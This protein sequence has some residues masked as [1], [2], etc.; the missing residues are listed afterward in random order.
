MSQRPAVALRKLLEALPDESFQFSGNPDQLISSVTWDYQAVGPGALYFCLEQEEFQEEHIQD[1]S[2]YHWKDALDAGAVCLVVKQ[3]SLSQVP[4][5]ISLIEVQNVNRAL[6]EISRAF[7]ENPFEKMKVIGITGTNG[8][9]TTSQLI[10]SILLCNKKKTGIIGTIGVFYPSG[11]QKTSHL[12]NP[13]ATELFSIGDQMRKEQVDYL[14][15]EVTS[16]AMAFERNYGIDFDVGVFTN[17]SQDHLDYHKTFDDYKS[18][19]LMHFESLGRRGK[20][21]FAVVNL[22]DTCG[23]EFI[24]ATDRHLRSTGKVEVLTFG[25]TN[26]EAV[27][28]A[29]PKNMTGAMSEFDVFLKSNFLCKIQLPMP[30]IFN[31]YNAM[32]AF[33]AAFTLGVNI[34]TIVQGLENARSIEGRFERL[35]TP[36]NFQ[37]FVDYAHTP[38]S[39]TQILQEVRKVTEKRVISVFGCGGDRDRTKRPLMGEAGSRLSDI[40]I[41]TSDNPR[42]EDPGEII[43]EI[44]AGISKEKRPKLFVEIDREKAVFLALKLAR[45]GDSV[46]IAGKGHESY[47]HIGSEKIPFSDR[48]VAL[49]FFELKTWQ[50]SRGWIEIRLDHLKHNLDLI[51]TDKPKDLKVMGV[52]KDDALGHGM[53]QTV[54]ALLLCGC[55]YLGVACMSEAMIIRQAG[56]E[57]IPILVFGE[58]LDEEIPDCIQYNLSIQVQSVKKAELIASL[59]KGS[60]RCIK[61]HFKVDTGMGRYGV[62]WDKAHEVFEEIK[63]IEGIEL[64]GIMTHFAQSDEKDKTYA[65]LQHERFE[66][67]LE[68]LRDKNLLP[69][70]AHCCNSGGYLDLPFAHHD[71]VRMGTLPIGVYPSKVCRR[72]GIEGEH[73]KPVMR[74]LGRIAFVK[75]LQPGDKMGYG[76]HFEAKKPTKIAV[77]PVGYGDGYPRLRNKGHVLIMGEV[78]PILGG[79]GMDGTMVDISAIKGVKEGDEAVLLGS[80]LEREITAN[81]LADWAGTVT[82]DILSRWSTRMDRCYIK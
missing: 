51:L 2:L 21:A 23:P 45:A 70:L 30:G 34:E 52:V 43:Q 47:Q 69:P 50:F 72:I 59:S 14:I 8:K 56:F 68:K 57:E 41:I 24:E 66:G 31:V 13:L 29:Y 54:K 16:H 7:F 65:K 5:R 33:A 81:M 80:Q 78:A 20:K 60:G 40:S 38:D 25:I 75:E 10:D 46:L 36:G 48:K 42:S 49:S 82:Y 28:V 62:R 11:R 18:K 76:M 4:D 37:V 27:L 9:T 19:K 73:L 53:I 17:L 74:V 22:D 15:M 32:A 6:S 79:N 3:G 61:V 67:V 77:I 12:S 44:V 71:M 55:D 64:E 1:N 35:E 26:K 58:R 39:L 63:A